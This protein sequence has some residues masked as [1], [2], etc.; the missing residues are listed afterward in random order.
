MSLC[1]AVIDPYS[2]RLVSL[3]SFSFKVAL[4]YLLY[5]IFAYHEY[6]SIDISFKGVY[7]FT[8]KAYLRYIIR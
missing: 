5:L 2:F 3:S 1:L 7:L 8:V 6:F 4:E